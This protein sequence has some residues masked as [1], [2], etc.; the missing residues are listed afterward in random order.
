MHFEQKKITP[1]F[2]AR[3]LKATRDAAEANIKLSDGNYF[4]Q[5]PLT[6]AT[7]TS[8]V[9]AFDS[10]TWFEKTAEPI[11]LSKINGHGIVVIDGQHR[12]EAIRRCGRPM[13]MTVAN[14]VPLE[15]FR[16]LDQGR[17]RTAADILASLGWPDH[18]TCA[19]MARLQYRLEETGDPRITTAE[20]RVPEAVIADRAQVHKPEMLS[21][22]ER[23]TPLAKLA[24]KRRSVPKTKICATAGPGAHRP[25]LLWCFFSSER[26][27]GEDETMAIAE[28]LAVAPE[29]VGNKLMPPKSATAPHA[30]W[31]IF[32]QYMANA[33]RDTIN[34]VG[35]QA[36]S[37]SVLWM[38]VVTAFP[39]AWN[40]A[41]NGG[42]LG[43]KKFT[44]EVENAMPPGQYVGFDDE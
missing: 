19:T 28:Y 8:Y 17:P 6:D 9:H 41:Q 21:I 32:Y 14:D 1:A 22:V 10:G 3:V 11:K 24:V 39:I 4:R 40:H 43:I 37:N 33:T 36:E 29:D 25:G 30:A 31:K 13:A 23:Y 34:H 15:A 18:S 2:A 35:K 16:F 38:L 26:L 44:T 12:L 7:V 42:R 27:V 20:I 5:R